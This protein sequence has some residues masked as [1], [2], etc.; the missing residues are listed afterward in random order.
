M[1]IIIFMVLEV[2]PVSDR[3]CPEIFIISF[4]I[5]SKNNI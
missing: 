4:F 5:S 2:F 3:R 1:W